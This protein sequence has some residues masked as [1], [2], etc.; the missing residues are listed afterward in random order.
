MVDISTITIVWEGNVS[1]QTI[2]QKYVNYVRNHTGSSVS[3]IFYVYSGDLNIVGTKSCEPPP[4]SP[5]DQRSMLYRNNF[6]LR[7]AN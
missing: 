3:I 7:V 1:I 2:C 4:P 5:H 6:Q